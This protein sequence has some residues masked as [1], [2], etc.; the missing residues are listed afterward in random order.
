MQN[1][2]LDLDSDISADI[3]E[4]RTIQ[5]VSRV[6]QNAYYF[7]D[8]YPKLVG[9]SFHSI[10]THDASK[11]S[12]EEYKPYI[13]HTACKFNK[14]YKLS[15]EAQAAFDKAW[16]HHIR[17]NDHHPEFWKPLSSM[18]LHAIIHCICDW[19][20]MSQEFNTSLREYAVKKLNKLSFSDEQKGFVCELVE[21]AEENLL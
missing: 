6:Q 3:F 16:G 13:L 19:T 7:A 15:I 20:A 11:W 4:M 9:M 8:L 1:I 21:L 5:H 18:P 14:K 2:I 10:A 12:I 17:I